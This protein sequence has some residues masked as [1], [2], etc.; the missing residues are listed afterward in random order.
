[1]DISSI[2]NLQIQHVYF[3]TEQLIIQTE[4]SAYYYLGK[5]AREQACNVSGAVIS[6]PGR[7]PF[8]NISWMRA[9]ENV[10]AGLSENG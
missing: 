4:D 6:M 8:Q 5:N 1:M 2:N 10:T 3:G 7:M 9:N